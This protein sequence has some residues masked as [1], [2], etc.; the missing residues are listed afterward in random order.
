MVYGFEIVANDD[1]VPSEPRKSKAEILIT[2]Y[3]YNLN[4]STGLFA[5]LQLDSRID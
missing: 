1:K 3:V 5:H 4:W 2:V